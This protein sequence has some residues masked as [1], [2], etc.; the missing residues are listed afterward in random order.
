MKRRSL[1]CSLLALIGPI[2]SAEPSTPAA[3]RERIERLCDA[4][5]ASKG[6]SFVRNGKEHSAD[7]AAKFLR[8][9]YK[10]M[11]EDVK[12]AEDFI[13][14]IATKSSMSGQ[15]YL[16][17]FSDGREMSSADFLRAQLARTSKK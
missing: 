6:L 7:D 1:L 4:V 17:R 15:P 16:V 14:K 5:A 11:G 2:A 3:E 13:N 10:A 9:K 12:T 8:E